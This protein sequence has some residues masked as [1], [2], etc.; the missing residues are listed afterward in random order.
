MGVSSE[1]GV[2]NHLGHVWGYPNLILADGAIVPTSTGRNPSH[3]IAALAERIAA[4]VS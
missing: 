1:S 4:H 2:V 3:T